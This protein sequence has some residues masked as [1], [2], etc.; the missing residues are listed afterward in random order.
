[1]IGKGGE[2]AV[3]T[4]AERTSRFLIP[5]PPVHRPRLADRHPGD[6]RLGDGGLPATIKRSLKWDRGSETAL[7][8]D[9]TATGLPVSFATRTHRGIAAATRTSTASSA[10]LPKSIEV[11]SD[12]S[13]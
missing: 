1:V 13:V 7:H 8:K 5:M 12:S 11:T 9:V 2:P 6:R 4:L 3:A 10:N